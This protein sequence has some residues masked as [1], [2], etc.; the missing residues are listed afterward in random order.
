[1]NVS[2]I[3]QTLREDAPALFAQHV[4]LVLVAM[5]ICIAIAIPLAVVF[6]RKKGS[7]LS[8]V[9]L[10]ILS[11]LQSVP[12]FAFIAIAMPLLGIG[13]LPSVVALIAQSLLPIIRSSMVG[14]LE[15]SPDAMEAAKGMGMSHSQILWQVE[16]PLA[17]KST[18]NGIR[19]ST[20]YAT[21]AAALAGYIGGGGLGVLISRGL[22]VFKNEYIIVGALLGAILAISLDALLGVVQKRFVY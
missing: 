7:M 17:M 11:I 5:I 1:M 8:A 12:S 15:V 13:F 10:R 16:L 3:L 4:M 20:V 22:S 21:S 18:I 14:I 19:T 9:V 2:L 6:T